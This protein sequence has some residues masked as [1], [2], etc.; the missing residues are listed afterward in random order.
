M[1]TGR[2]TSRIAGRE[3]TTAADY[4]SRCVPRQG[5]PPMPRHRET[6]KN[7]DVGGL[8]E[9]LP[10]EG[11][12]YTKPRPNRSTDPPKKIRPLVP[13]TP[14]DPI[15]MERQPLGQSVGLESFS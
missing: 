9:V 11:V 13:I 1:R 8:R 15:P 5:V 2:G 14:P 10:M 3:K 6:A 7:G 12:Y 4:R